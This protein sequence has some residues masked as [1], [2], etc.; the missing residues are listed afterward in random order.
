MPPKTT[1]APAETPETGVTSSPEAA[2][3]APE[4][5]PDAGVPPEAKP[6][7]TTPPEIPQVETLNYDYGTPAADSAP[8][9]VTDIKRRLTVKCVRPQG[10]WRAGKFWPNEE[11]PVYEA[12][13][14]PETLEALQAEPL[15][16]VKEVKE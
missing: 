11:V 16:I 15:L 12:D 7:A 6:A 1:K 3:K 13:L 10:V 2:I 5:A 14:T 4:P 9:E 8:P